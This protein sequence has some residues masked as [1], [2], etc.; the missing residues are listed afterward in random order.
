MKRLC[1]ILVLLVTVSVLCVA[2]AGTWI[3]DGRGWWYQEAD[4]SY[5]AASW[6]KIRNVWYYFDGNG[7]MA[8]GWLNQAGKTY[9]LNAS[10][11]MDTGWQQ[12][13]GAWYYFTPS[14]ELMRNA[15][16]S[17]TYYVNSQGVMLT[18]TTTPDGYRVG[19]DG[20]WI[21]SHSG[22]N[23]GFQMGSGYAT[24]APYVGNLNSMKFHR[25]TCSQLSN[26]SPDH[27]LDMYSREEA[28]R[29][30][31]IPCRKCNP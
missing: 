13:G 16:I 7:Y 18:N 31:F 22:G 14:G 11:A 4:G 12:I 24:E 9:H 23:G 28:I 17:G 26:M 27:K 30:G 21:P 20:R 3:R 15:W 8:T 29:Q 1:A 19:S 2:Q 6:R 25:N 10:G 5:P